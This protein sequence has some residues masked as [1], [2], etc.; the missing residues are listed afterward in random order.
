MSTKKI[1][2]VGILCAMAMVV[3]LLISF[4]LVPAV[5]FLKYD[6][7]DIIIVMGGFIYGPLTAMLMSFIC[8]VLEI[9]FRGGNALDILMNM[10]STCSFACVA[11]YVYYKQHTKKGAIIGLVAGVIISAAIMCLWNYVITPIY[12]G[13]PRAEVVA[14]LLPGILPFNLIKTGGNA[15]ITMVLYKPFVTIL[16]HNN[17]ANKNDE[18]ANYGLAWLIMFVCVSIMLFVLAKGG[19]I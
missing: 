2:T 18:K 7:K 17:L 12:Y 13:W 11:A 16:R 3:N 4:P 9:M 1:T 6:P 15:A 14:I 5:S 8:S 19:T 10:V